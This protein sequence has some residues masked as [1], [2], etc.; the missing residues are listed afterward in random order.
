MDKQSIKFVFKGSLDRVSKNRVQ[1]I[2][3]SFNKHLTC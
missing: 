3:S 1:S 2:K